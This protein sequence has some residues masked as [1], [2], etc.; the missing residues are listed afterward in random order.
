M[1]VVSFP[2]RLCQPV[3]ERIDA[4][5]LFF[6]GFSFIKPRMGLLVQQ[7]DEN[8][9]SKYGCWPETDPDSQNNTQHAAAEPGC[10]VSIKGCP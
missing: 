1:S 3:A 8:I 7:F 5:R 2:M 10:L 4:L 9:K 6:Y